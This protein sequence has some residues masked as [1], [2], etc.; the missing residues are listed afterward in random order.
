MPRFWTGRAAGEVAR[1]EFGNAITFTSSPQ[2]PSSGIF[3]LLGGNNGR[4]QG[5][6]SR[7]SRKDQIRW[8]TFLLGYRSLRGKAEPEDKPGGVSPPKPAPAVSNLSRKQPGLPPSTPLILRNAA[9]TVTAVRLFPSMHGQSAPHRAMDRL[10]LR[11]TPKQFRVLSRKILRC[12]EEWRYS[13]LVAL[14]QIIDELIYGR[15][16]RLR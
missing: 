6:R 10:S 4:H 14:F 12:T 3:L 5:T 9:V 13:S 15:L 2:H 1:R 16:F 7:G 11:G 8:Q